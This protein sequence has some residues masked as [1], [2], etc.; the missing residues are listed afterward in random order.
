MARVHAD[1]RIRT[2]IIDRAEGVWLFDSEG[3]AFLDGVSSMWCNVHGHRHPQIDRAIK[4][5]LDAVAHVTSLG[6]SN[7]TTV[8]LVKRLVQSTPAGLECV[9]FA[10]DG[11][12][13]V[14]VALKLAF[15]YW[16]QVADP[17]P[18][19]DLYLALGDAYHGDTLGSVS[20]GGVSRFHAMFDPLL[21]K[22]VRGP[23]PTSSELR[24]MF[25][26]RK[27]PTITCG[28]M[29]R[30]SNASKI[31]LRQSSSNHWFKVPPGWSCTRLDFCAACEN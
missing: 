16:R 17:Q 8:R 27:P 29:N 2:L 20:V 11:A 21:F 4:H 9:F 3:N 13:A 7:T 6:M 25:R 1:V 24:K 22:V 23:V 15:Q 18:Q 5:Q 26:R 10:S 19:R 30:S 12:C 14:E 28:N 31:D